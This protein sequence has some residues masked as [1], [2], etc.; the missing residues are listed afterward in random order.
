MAIIW[1]LMQ[2]VNL[3]QTNI[4]LEKE[5][6]QVQDDVEKKIT[7]LQMQMMTAL[8]AALEKKKELES[9]LDKANQTILELRDHFESSHCLVDS[10]N[11]A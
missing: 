9:E 11:V 8:S 3:K 6:K 10:N 4:R 5:N 7:E 1:I 2:M